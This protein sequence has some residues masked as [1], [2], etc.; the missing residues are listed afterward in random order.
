MYFS[1]EITFI[2]KDSHIITIA[3]QVNN[4]EVDVLSTSLNEAPNIYAGNN[5]LNL[6]DRNRNNYEIQ[7]A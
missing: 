4:E 5:N 3:Q 7:T 2:E 1:R 6:T